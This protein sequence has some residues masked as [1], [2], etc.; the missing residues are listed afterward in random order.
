M[1]VIAPSSAPSA[2]ALQGQQAQHTNDAEQTSRLSEKVEPGLSD[3][4][5]LSQRPRPNYELHYTLSGHTLSISA[6]KFS[7]DGKTLASSGVLNRYC[8]M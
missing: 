3:A 8:A 1:Y 6:I 5:L 2:M 7:P 4:L